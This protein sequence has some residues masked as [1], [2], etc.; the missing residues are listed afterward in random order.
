MTSDPRPQSRPSL[1]TSAAPDQL[2]CG[3]VVNTAWSST[4]SQR[5]A[6][7]CFATTRASMLC[8]FAAAADDRHRVADDER[9]GACRAP[10]TRPCKRQRRLDEREAAVEVVADDEAR[11][12]RVARADPDVLGF[13]HDVADRRDQAV[14]ANAHAVTDALGAE[15]PG[16]HRVVGHV[17]RDRHDGVVGHGRLARSRCSCG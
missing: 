6:N 10:S 5:P 15:Q 2:S 13:V 12:D 4:Y 16:A 7:S 17:R 9:I 11:H 3:G 1:S 14:V 8:S